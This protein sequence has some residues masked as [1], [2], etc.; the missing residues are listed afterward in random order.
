[1]AR[2]Y[3][4]TGFWIRRSGEA[5]AG[6]MGRIM[7]AFAMTILLSGTAQAQSR[8]KDIVDFEGIRGSFWPRSPA[9]R[10]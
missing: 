6:L 9:R 2:H 7:L 4:E 1:M 5:L 8:I 10:A 3:A